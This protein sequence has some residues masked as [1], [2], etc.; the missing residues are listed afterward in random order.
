MRLSSDA[1][2]A[3]ALLLL[4]LA[5]RAVFD[6]LLALAPDFRWNPDEIVPDDLSYL[7]AAVRANF[8]A[9]ASDTEMPRCP[10]HRAAASV[11]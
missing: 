1:A 11:P 3:L 6:K 5:A 2:A 7:D 8:D 4:S 10:R 9:S